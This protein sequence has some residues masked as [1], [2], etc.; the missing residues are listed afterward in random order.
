MLLTSGCNALL[1]IASQIAGSDGKF[2]RVYSE[3]NL[4]MF[5]DMRR[6]FGPITVGL[7][8]GA[9][10]L[11][12]VLTGV[13]DILGS[14]MGGS[15]GYAAVVN[16]DTISLTDFNRE[17]QQRMEYFQSMMKGKMD[18]KILKKMGFERQ[19][20]NEL[21]RRQLLLQ[22]AEKLGLRVS[23]QE[24]KDKIQDLPYFKKEG[25]FD[26]SYYQKLLAANSI[27]PARFEENIREDLLRQKFV[28]M[29][30][31][32]ARAS[33]AEVHD[34][35][36]IAENK[37]SVP[38]IFISADRFM[39]KANTKP[40]TAVAAKPPAVEPAVKPEEAAK[41][42]RAAADALYAQIKGLSPDRAQAIVK[43]KG[44]ELK[45][46]EAFNRNAAIPGVG[47]VPDLTKDAFEAASPLLKEAK[48]Y[49]TRGSY[50]IAFAP[51]VHAPD[52]SKFDKEKEHLAESLVDKKRQTILDDWLGD[53]HQRAKVK[54][55]SALAQQEKE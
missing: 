37:R 39:S 40:K 4:F 35:F 27:Q 17:Y 3:A 48:L 47:Y 33:D 2:F 42:A 46:S 54:I 53:A 28:S 22:Q 38:Y 20:L 8:V 9:I 30:Y 18:P 23:D 51:R 36:L 12:F 16:G 10:A 43:A 7:I 50:V 14:R 1:M 29:V 41:K 21:V 25:K 44:F 31:D 13:F 49:E 45:T 34:A 55:N 11:T 15:G 19:V 32:F 6:V 24:L 26:A 52:L 5:G